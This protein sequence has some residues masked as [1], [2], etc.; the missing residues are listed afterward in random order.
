M[1][2]IAVRGRFALTF[3]RIALGVALFALWEGIS[4]PVI[5]KFYL[6]RPSEIAV[7]FWGSLTSGQLI[8]DLSLS[9]YATLVGFAFGAL[10]GLALGLLL[11]L[12]QMAA[13]VTRP[14]ILA[15]YGI[16]RIA[17]APVFILWFG[18]GI[19]SKE[20]MAGMATFLLVFF[21]TYEGIRAAD[22]GLRNVAMV[23]GATR[24]K[25]FF[26]VTLPNASPWIIA[27]LR[28]A[29]PQALVAAVVAEFIASTAGLGY[30]IMETTYTLNTAGTM[31]GILVLMTVVVV[32][33]AVLDRFEDHVLRWRPKE[34]DTRGDQST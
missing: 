1:T 10:V 26:Y 20:M 5:D 21:N 24:W 12:N 19:L 29:I 9:L 30:R 7:Y 6:S 23:M 4:G 15:V 2:S 34:S 31:S 22:L 14:Y 11:S 32:L 16:P 27:G 13:D 25:L 17:L 28:I 8:A 3:W 18:I 33:N